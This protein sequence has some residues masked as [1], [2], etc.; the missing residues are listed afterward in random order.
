MRFDGIGTGISAG[1]FD[2]QSNLLSFILRQAG[3]VFFAGRCDRDLVFTGG[4]R[5]RFGI[6]LYDFYFGFFQFFV[7]VGNFPRLNSQCFQ[8]VV[9]RHLDVDEITCRIR[10]F[11]EA[12]LC[13]GNFL[14]V[15]RQVQVIVLRVLHFIGHALGGIERSDSGPTSGLYKIAA[16]K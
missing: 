11:Y 8:E 4:Q 13:F 16:L 2:D 14:V 7:E 12:E 1:N 15:D 9:C 6:F 3:K 5:E 10:L